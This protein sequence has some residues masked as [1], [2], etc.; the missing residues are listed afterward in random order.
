MHRPIFFIIRVISRYQK[1]KITLRIWDLEKR[2][3]IN[4]D[5]VSTHRL[6]VLAIG[7]AKN[8]TY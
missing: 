5:V 1:R 6:G 4:L 7:K 2:I 3:L 8:F